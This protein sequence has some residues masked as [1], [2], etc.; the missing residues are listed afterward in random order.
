MVYYLIEAIVSRCERVTPLG[1]HLYVFHYNP[2]REV[3]AN[4]G[5]ILN[6]SKNGAIKDSGL[7]YIWDVSEVMMKNINLAVMYRCSQ[8]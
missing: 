6:W 4:E 3:S 2:S 8:E 5:C 1:V 7:D